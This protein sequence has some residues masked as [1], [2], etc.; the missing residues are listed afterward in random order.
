MSDLS[1]TKSLALEL[2]PDG[3]RVNAVCPGSVDTPIVAEVASRFPA[4]LDPRAT[5]RLMAM[6][7]GP[8]ITPAELG[9][10][11][12]YLASKEA[13]MITGTVLAFDG[14]MT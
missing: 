9:S 1:L 8:S 7:P 4:D 10:S 12:V 13:R 11:I 5:D 3:I 6:L 14:G 2:A